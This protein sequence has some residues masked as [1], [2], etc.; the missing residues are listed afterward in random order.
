MKIV[1]FTAALL[2]LR[3]GITYAELPQ[4]AVRPL[5][6]ADKSGD[7]LITIETSRAQPTAGSGFGLSAQIKNASEKPITI[8]EKTTTLLLPPEVAGSQDLGES[9]YWAYFTTES[10]TYSTGNAYESKLT[11]APGDAY[12]V[13]WSWIPPGTQVHKTV[14]SAFP[15]FI[16]TICRTIALEL[17]FVFFPPGDYKASVIVRY[18]V[19]GEPAESYRTATQSALIHVNAPQSVILFGAAVGGLLGYAISLMFLS[20]KKRKTETA[21]KSRTANILRLLSGA[22]GSILL[23]AIVTILLSRLSET[24]FLI[25]VTINDFW[26]AIAMGFVANLVGIKILQKILSSAG[27][28]SQ[29]SR[30]QE[31]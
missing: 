19:E 22:I 16:V 23:S 11:I 6:S 1:H 5:Q 15:Q 3:C 26:G 28:D 31:R 25:R 14:T 2:I 4:P 9:T 12:T 8:S 10:S 20:D 21:T 24:Q 17:Q 29:D 13:A 7:I 27:S 30:H 18:H